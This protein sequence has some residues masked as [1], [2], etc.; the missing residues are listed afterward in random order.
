[1][2]FLLRHFCFEQCEKNS[3]K[4]F[5][6]DVV[7]ETNKTIGI[8]KTVAFHWWKAGVWFEKKYLKKNCAQTN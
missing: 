4:I 5:R 1:M 3:G 8:S 7:A 6:D 2:F